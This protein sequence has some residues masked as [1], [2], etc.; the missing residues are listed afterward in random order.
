M[1]LNFTVI[2]VLSG[3][4]LFLVRSFF[5]EKKAPGQPEWE[6][7]MSVGFESWTILKCFLDS[8]RRPEFFE[9]GQTF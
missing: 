8:S 2:F 5:E 1:G 9:T 4:Y 7:A 3:L 6:T